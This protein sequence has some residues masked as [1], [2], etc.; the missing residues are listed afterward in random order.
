MSEKTYK[1]TFLRDSGVE[2]FSK[3]TKYPSELSDEDAEFKLFKDVGIYVVQIF[4]KSEMKDISVKSGDRNI[5]IPIED[6]KSS[7]SIMGLDKGELKREY[8]VTI[9]YEN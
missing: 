7:L 2:D 5:N 8:E 6:N 3:G 1:L 9:V 4:G